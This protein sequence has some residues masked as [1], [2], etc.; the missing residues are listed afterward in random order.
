[1]FGIKRMTRQEIRAAKKM[2]P[3]I[4]VWTAIVVVLTYIAMMALGRC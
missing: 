4:T 2:G 1:M 3:F